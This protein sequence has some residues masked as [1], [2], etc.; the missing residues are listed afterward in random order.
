[1]SGVIIKIVTGAVGGAAM[2]LLGYLKQGGASNEAEFDWKKFLPG[3][4]IAGIFGGIAGATDMD[5]SAVE[6]MPYAALISSGVVMGWK[7]V[8]RRL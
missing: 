5:M 2:S 3:V 4:I 7:A 8:I 1:M 6:T